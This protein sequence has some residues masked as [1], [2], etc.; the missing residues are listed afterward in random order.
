METPQP[1]SHIPFSSRRGL[2]QTQNYYVLPGVRV[3]PT[4]S[5]YGP[6]PA[7]VNALTL[8][9]KHLQCSK[10][11]NSTDV[12]ET[13]PVNDLLN[14]YSYPNMMPFLESNGGWDQENSSTF[15]SG[16]FQFKFVGAESG[17]GWTTQ[18]IYCS[19]HYQ[20]FFLFVCL[21]VC[22][23]LKKKLQKKSNSKK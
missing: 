2:Q 7:D 16:A 17:A 14:W 12:D 19:I 6:F 10:P 13:E 21:F 5:V 15:S 1:L 11:L 4:I 20:G 18:I 9:S 3:H 23:F 8:N 22:L